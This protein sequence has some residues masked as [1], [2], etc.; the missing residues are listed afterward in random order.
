MLGLAAAAASLVLA[1]LP[2]PSCVFVL[3]ASCRDLAAYKMHVCIAE[4]R[5]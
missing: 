1:W 3:L 5:W 2:T 4:N